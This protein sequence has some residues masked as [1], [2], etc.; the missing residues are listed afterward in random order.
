M[1]KSILLVEDD[2]IISTLLNDLLKDKDFNVTHVDDGD[3]VLD[4]VKETN[5]DLI[6]LDENL[7]TMNGSEVLVHLKANPNYATI[8]II[9]LTSLDDTDFQ[10]TIINE[11]VDDYI[12]KPFRMNLLLARINNVLR[13]TSD[14]PKLDIVIPEGSDPSALNDRERDIIKQIVKGYN[15]QKIAEALFLSESTVTNYI[16]SIFSKLK[17]TNRTQTAIIAIK[18]GLIE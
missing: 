6:L 8:P 5:F 1:M 9:M 18:L 11:G 12:T 3:K 4:A 2:P 13:K 17:T 15:N 16:K 14:I 10:A 7:P